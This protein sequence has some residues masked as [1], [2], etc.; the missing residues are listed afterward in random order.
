MRR[1]SSIPVMAAGC[2]KEN[3]QS[4]PLER[5]FLPLDRCLFPSAVHLSPSGPVAYHRGDVLLS[6]CTTVSVSPDT[7]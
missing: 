2:A 7:A 5:T 3:A 4:L 1:Q 6:V